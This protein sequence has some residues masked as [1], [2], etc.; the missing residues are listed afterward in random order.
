MHNT[1]GPAPDTGHSGL[2][3][4]ARH[5]AAGKQILPTSRQSR[6]IAALE[7]A[8]TWE[9]AD[10]CG[11]VEDKNSGLTFRPQDVRAEQGGCVVLV[12]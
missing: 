12:F 3:V 9:V 6:D 8:W 4:K 11:S 10:V 5:A 1:S 2:R 7:V